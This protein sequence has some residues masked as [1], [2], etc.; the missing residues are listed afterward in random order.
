VSHLAKRIEAIEGRSGNRVANERAWYEKHDA[1][2]HQ[3]SVA[4]MDRAR[5]E[6]GDTEETP[7]IEETPEHREKRFELWNKYHDQFLATN[8][9]WQ[10]LQKTKPAS[11]K[12]C[13]A[14]FRSADF[15]QQRE[16]HD[17]KC[18]EIIAAYTAGNVDHANALRT[19]QK[20]VPSEPRP[21]PAPAIEPVEIPKQAKPPAPDKLRDYQENDSTKLSGEWRDA[22]GKDD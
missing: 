4:A 14:F 15:R 3:S 16:E 11:A 1:I 7:E 13:E 6:L 10:K 5:E 12:H 19:G 21:E 22:F 17:A 8:P 20:Y 18:R 9:T 2:W